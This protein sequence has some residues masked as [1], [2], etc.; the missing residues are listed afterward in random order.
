MREMR[1]SLVNLPMASHSRA[2]VARQFSHVKQK[3]S[4]HL[5]PIPEL[6]RM[7]ND[8]HIFWSTSPPAPEL[9]LGSELAV[10]QKHHVRVN[11][12]DDAR[13]ISVNQANCGRRRRSRSVETGH[14]ALLLLLQGDG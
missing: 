6:P 7:N 1:G 11:C 9:E 2:R 3:R 12:D 13:R 4:A 10:V 8:H 14:L 5:D